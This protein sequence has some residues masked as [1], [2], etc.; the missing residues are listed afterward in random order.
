MCARPQ[1][2]RFPPWQT[3]PETP[4]LEKRARLRAVFLLWFSESGYMLVSHMIG[5]VAE[6]PC[7][8]GDEEV[9]GATLC[10]NA[11]VRKVTERTCSK[12]FEVSSRITNK[13]C[14]KF[15]KLHRVLHSN[16]RFLNQTDF[17]AAFLLTGRIKIYPLISSA[18][19]VGR[20][21]TPKSA[22][23]QGKVEF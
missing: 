20:R 9:A 4:K 12:L 5:E 3:P 8:E 1:L 14:L 17:H 23:E 16:F 7:W 19:P 10:C 2:L 6:D 18:W 21:N 13:N 22:K 11:M 15:S